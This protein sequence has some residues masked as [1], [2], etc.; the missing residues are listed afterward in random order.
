[1]KP[2]KSPPHG[3]AAERNSREVV[4]MNSGDPRD[5]IQALAER[6]AAAFVTNTKIDVGG[7][8]GELAIVA[9]STMVALDMPNELAAERAISAEFLTRVDL[10]LRYS[11]QDPVS[12]ER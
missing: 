9:Y 8:L 7:L 2:G 10:C 11:N 3:A 4:A 1:M 5:V 12:N 6:A